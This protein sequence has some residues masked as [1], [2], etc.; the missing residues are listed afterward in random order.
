MFLKPHLEKGRIAKLSE[1][2]IKG[3]D[4]IVLVLFLNYHQFKADSLKGE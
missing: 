3:S 2:L 4:V 1:W